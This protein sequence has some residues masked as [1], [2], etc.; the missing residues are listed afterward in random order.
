MKMLLDFSSASCLSVWWSVLPPEA[1]RLLEEWVSRRPLFPSGVLAVGP[2]RAEPARVVV[3]GPESPLIDWELVCSA[4]LAV[5]IVDCD[6]VEL[7]DNRSHSSVAVDE[8]LTLEAIEVR[9]DRAS[10]RISSVIS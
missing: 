10:F 3:T 7:L 6:G 2:G 8:L 4:L 1:G 9:E 5:C